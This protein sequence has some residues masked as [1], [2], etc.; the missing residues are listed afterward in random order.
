MSVRLT[1][2]TRNLRGLVANLSAADAVM[3]RQAR[4]TV[5]RYGEK[6]WRLTR[7][8]AP[9]DTGFLRE[10]IRLRFSEDGLIYEVGFLEED[11][12]E[13]GL[14]FYAIFTE[15]GTRFM[16]P[17]PCV[18]PARDAIAPEFRSALG[19]NIRGALRRRRRAA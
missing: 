15:W 8:L 18:F 16:A 14:P 11:F 7:E 3:Q 4:R 1:I 19:A 5:K 12:R 6:Q 2:S 9:V 13:A 17:R 10:H